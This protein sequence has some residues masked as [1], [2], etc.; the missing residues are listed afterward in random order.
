[1]TTKALLAKVAGSINASVNIDDRVTLASYLAA[2]EHDDEL[3]L[4]CV[5][6]AVT[7]LRRFSEADLVWLRH[8]LPIIERDLTKT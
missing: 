2:I 7:K 4:R 1:M 3:F 5:K 8:W 6:K